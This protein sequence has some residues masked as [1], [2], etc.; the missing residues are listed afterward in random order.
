MA[1]ERSWA[2]G[3]EGMD[4]T[5]EVVG[6]ILGLMLN[7]IVAAIKQKEIDLHPS[8]LPLFIGSELGCVLRTKDGTQGVTAVLRS[9]G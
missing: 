3:I 5:M 7:F 1:A 8:G 2:V 4:V 6:L 9:T